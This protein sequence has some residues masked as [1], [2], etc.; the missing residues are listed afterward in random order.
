MIQNA[1]LCELVRLGRQRFGCDPRY[2]LRVVSE[3]FADR[4]GTDEDDRWLLERICNAYIKAIQDGRSASNIFAPTKWWKQIR[5]KQLGPV[6]QALRTRNV[7][8]LRRM[9]SNLFRDPC[10]TGL[11]GL[12][13]DMQRCYFNGEID[14]LHGSFFL[15]DAL[16]RLDLWKAWTQG[17]FP[18][19]VLSSPVIGNP[20]GVSVDGVF[21]RMAAEYQHFYAQEIAGL[22]GPQMGGTVLEIGGGFGGMAYYLLRDNP[23]LRYIN[24]DVPETIALASYYLL[25][26]FPAL[27]AT[28]YGEAEITTDLVNKSDIILMPSFQFGEL[29]DDSA[30]VSFSSHVLTDLCP[31]SAYEYTDQ[32]ARTTRNHILLLDLAEPCP[33]VSVSLLQN[34]DKFNLAR[35][36]AT[37]WDSAR[38]LRTNQVEW[39]Y[40]A[41][42]ILTEA[43]TTDVGQ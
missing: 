21:I 41:R 30:D 6:T 43:T 39:L 15:S 27:T 31:E 19:D 37:F 5:A 25:K 4:H 14:A 1:E 33:P 22:L 8:S 11:V 28:L 29:R 12:P 3:G 35:K 34:S 32:L 17:R 13:V 9:Y 38:A 42:K 18:V 23:G 16:H 24:F 7:D 40:T 2:C 36:R 26:S 10:S 20:Y